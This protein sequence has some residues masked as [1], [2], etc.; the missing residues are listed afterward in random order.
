MLST[1]W[2]NNKTNG[3]KLVSLYST[4]KMMHGPINIRNSKSLRSDTSFWKLKS[5]GIYFSSVRAVRQTVGCVMKRSTFQIPTRYTGQNTDATVMASLWQTGQSVGV[6]TT[7]WETEQCV[8]VFMR[9]WTLRGCHRHCH[10][11]RWLQNCTAL[12]C[13]CWQ[14]AHSAIVMKQTLGTNNYSFSFQN[15]T[16]ECSFATKMG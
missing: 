4:I 11:T 14:R 2:S 8:D 1:E 16:T 7:R 6:A 13:P 10:S 15:T 12:C 9:D 3:I 5:M